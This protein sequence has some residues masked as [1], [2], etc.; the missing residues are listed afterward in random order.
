MGEEGDP[1]IPTAAVTALNNVV[2]S[3]SLP[4]I[5]LNWWA[6]HVLGSSRFSLTWHMP[7]SKEV[8]VFQ[9]LGLESKGQETQVECV[10]HSALLQTV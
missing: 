4:K 10:S 3:L 9:G 2:S 6:R 8:K 1:E 5:Q 7:P